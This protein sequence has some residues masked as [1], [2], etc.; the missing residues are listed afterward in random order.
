[1]VEGELLTLQDVTIAATA[2]AGSAGNNSEEATSL[3][4]LLESGL[5]LALGGEAGGLLLLYGAALLGGLVL[6]LSLLLLTSAAE[7]LTVVGLI[8]LAERGGIDLDNGGLG[9]GVCTDQLVVRRVV[10]DDDDTGLAG[11]AF[12]GPGKVARVETKGTVL[13]VAAAS[14]DD[15]DSLRADT[16]VGL[17]TAGLESALLPW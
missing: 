5:D 4:L 6:G 14:A 12:G 9:Q 15:V 10:G 16:G 11:A 1:L 17:L 7:G 13:V 3:E 8:P 2:L